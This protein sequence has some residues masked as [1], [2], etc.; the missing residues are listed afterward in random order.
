MRR[1]YL[2][3]FLLMVGLVVSAFSSPLK[4]YD[5]FG[6]C[7]GFT[8]HW[9]RGSKLDS[10]IMLTENL[11]IRWSREDFLW[12]SIE[13]DSALYNM[14]LLAKYDTLLNKTLAH[15]INIYGI[16]T[17]SESQTCWSTGDNDPSTTKHFRDFANFCTFVVDY[18][19]GKIKYW[20]IWNEPDCP[21]FWKP[22]PDVQSY[23]QML[24]YVYPA[25]KQV[26][27][28][29]VVLAPAYGGGDPEFLFEIF[30]NNGLNYMDILSM[31]AYSY[32]E[33]GSQTTFE[34]S[35]VYSIIDTFRDSMEYYGEVKP[36]WITETGVPTHKG[37][38]GS[39]RDRQATVLTRMIMLLIA[40]KIGH[41]DWYDLIDDGNDSTDREQNFGLVS[42]NLTPK[43]AYTALED[44][45]RLLDGATYIQEEDIGYENKALIFKTADKK[46]L[47]AL[48]TFEE[49]YEND[50]FAYAVP[51]SV[52]MYLKNPPDSVFDIFGQT[53][54]YNFIRDTIHITLNDKPVFVKGDFGYTTS[55]E[56]YWLNQGISVELPNPRIYFSGT[57]LTVLYELGLMS[58]ISIQLYDIHG[59]QLNTLVDKQQY[60]GKYY[61]RWNSRLSPG[62]YIVT[63]E[64]NYH[65]TATKTLFVR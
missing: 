11:G 65:R 45:V 52:T 41:I 48:W 25:I 57:V 7:A 62:L 4:A 49:V 37:P 34:I 10:V 63:V 38:H 20:E 19:K 31:H 39:S 5:V 53:I 8:R 61:V 29:L 26:D 56:D 59:R 44:L 27:S 47:L 30:R 33:P 15:G 46:D 2:S 42:C 28:S 35:S 17:A 50:T 14:D 13:V 58:H 18:F 1:N 60:R 64:S 24:K 9:W 3:G 36:V 21:E 12:E 16:L 23:I 22:Q 51:E 55:S 54:T 43:I 40:K 6:L 32:D